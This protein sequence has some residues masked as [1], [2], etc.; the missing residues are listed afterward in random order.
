MKYLV[1]EF[2]I[3][4]QDGMIQICRD[5]LTDALGEAGFETFED[6]DD[7]I[8]GYVQEQLLDRPAMADII[9]NFMLPDVNI[10]TEIKEAEYKNW[11][12]QWEEAGFA[13]ICI[14]GRICIYDARHEDGSGSDADI[15]IGIETKQAFGTGTHETT[16]MIIATLL[17][18]PIHGK[19]LLDCGCGTG[20]L[21]IAASKLGAAEVVGYDIDEW[22]SENALHN[23]DINNVGNMKV[24]L[25]DASVI[26]N[27]DGKFDFVL[28]NINRN[29]LLN[30]M[31]SFAKAITADGLLILSGF[32]ES[33]A[34]LLKEKA[35]S[36]GLHEIG[37]KV[38][39]E[40]TCLVLKAE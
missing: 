10:S 35:A 16:R 5:L 2:K 25:G 23:A 27:I 1:A 19:R 37:R 32:Y 13:P 14:N 24:M 26:D 8:K 17:E 28:A 6:T 18:L 15:K 20:I 12:Q 31:P 36:L 34:D 11:N 40:W 7:G 30:D 39:N 38:D 9:H 33:D 29:I 22:S 21:G 3:E 4:C